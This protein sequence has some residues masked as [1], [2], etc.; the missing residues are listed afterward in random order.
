MIDKLIRR[1]GA[2]VRGAKHA[3]GGFGGV[4]GRC[5]DLELL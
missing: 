3:N 4:L 2:A 5:F 1:I